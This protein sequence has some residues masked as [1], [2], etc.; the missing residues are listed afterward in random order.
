MNL[1]S[2]YLE[3][4]CFCFCFDCFIMILTSTGVP[5]TLNVMTNFP[6][7]VVGVLGFVFALDGSFFNI[8]F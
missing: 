2:E 1:Q 7:L 4:V 3:G 8:R 6:F 5:N